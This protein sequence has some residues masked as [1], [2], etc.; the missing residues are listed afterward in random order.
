MCKNYENLKLPKVMFPKI[1]Q[2]REYYCKL[3]LQFA[4]YML[5][6]AHDASSVST[7]P[8]RTRKSLTSTTPN[9]FSA[10]QFTAKT[11]LPAPWKTSLPNYHQPFKSHVKLPESIEARGRRQARSPNGKNS[12]RGRRTPSPLRPRNK[13]I[14]SSTSLTSF[15]NNT[16][17]NSSYV[18]YKTHHQPT[19]R[20]FTR[21]S[22]KIGGPSSKQHHT[23]MPHHT[24]NKGRTSPASLR[25]PGPT[26]GGPGNNKGQQPQQP[27]QPPKPNTID[28][29]SLVS[30]ALG[31]V[32]VVLNAIE[33]FLLKRLPRKMKIYELLIFSMSVSDL[34]FGAVSFIMHAYTFA[35]PNA[36]DDKSTTSIWTT[37]YFIL[38]VSSILHLLTI[39]A[40]RLFAVVR[41]V[42]HNIVVRRMR[43]VKVIGVVWTVSVLLGSSLYIS[44]NMSEMFK[45]TEITYEDES[46]NSTITNSTSN[47]TDF[48]PN[49][50][51]TFYLEG[52]IG[53]DPPISTTQ[54]IFHDEMTAAT[55]S[56]QQQ[57]KGKVQQQST[58]RPHFIR[59]TSAINKN[60]NNNNNNKNNQQKQRQPPRIKHIRYIDEYK[61]IM[62]RWLAYVI[63]VADTALVTIYGLIIAAICNH[64]HN[65]HKHRSVK[66]SNV[67]RVL[68]VCILIAL[69]FVVF[70]LP[71]S[72]QN[73]L[74]HGNPQ[75]ASI[76]LVVNS[77]INSIVFFMRGEY[78]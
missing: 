52:S 64:H 74:N 49:G 17:K 33:V 19:A 2:S 60:N 23:T 20:L 29:L 24:I 40:D 50:N 38:V 76:L 39:A 35:V 34:L 16:S 36:K 77:G 27:Q 7:L 8:A 71:F 59:T 15:N 21:K 12:R 45:K 63:I 22:N 41:P 55:L 4:I 14:S 3:L 6:L 62:E 18:R 75:W 37:L 1:L 44:N 47:S 67:K 9:R 32:V 65:T 54:T 70:T 78:K 26:D 31:V 43:V 42:K 72:I 48:F 58:R 61:I 13:P 5:I 25:P 30:L 66:T 69:A 11:V 73:F 46:T 68:L 10:V 53:D 57:S 51:T 28:P 56:P